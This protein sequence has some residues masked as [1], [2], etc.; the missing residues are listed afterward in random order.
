M[1]Q[2]QLAPVLAVLGGI[3]ELV[4]IVGPIFAG[5]TA[6]IIALA[7]APEKAIW[8]ALVFLL[9]QGVENL[10]LVPRIQGGFMRVHPA[11]VLIV[12]AVGAKIVGI[13]GLILAVPVTATVFAIYQQA[14]IAPQNGVQVTLNSDDNPSLY[15]CSL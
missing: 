10:L 15:H 3:G 12:V 5:V 9:V 11:I 7:T 6:T 14:I 2:I 1:L 13:W 4:P 8:V